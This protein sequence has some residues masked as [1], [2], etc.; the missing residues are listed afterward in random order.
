[1][2]GATIDGLQATAGSADYIAMREALV[3]LFIH[4]DYT[5]G[6]VSGQVEIREDRTIFHNAGISLVSAEG[7]VDGGKS[8]SRNSIISRALRLIGF[9]ELAGPGCTPCI[10]RGERHAGVRLR[11]SQTPKRIPSH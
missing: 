8:T 4:Q 3:N 5:N 11:S 1:M 2:E 10:Q 6:G 9:A 7:L